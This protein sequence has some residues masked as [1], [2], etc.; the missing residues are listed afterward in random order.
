MGYTMLR[1]SPSLCDFN[2]S[3]GVYSV[4]QLRGEY[5]HALALKAIA[6]AN[7]EPFR[8]TPAVFSPPGYMKYNNQCEGDQESTYPSYDQNSLRPEYYDDYGDLIATYL[9]LL[10]DSLGLDIYAISLQNEPFFNEPYSSC[11]YAGGTHY[12]EMLRVAGPK[13]RQA[14]YATLL[15]GCEHMAWA[16]PSW[17]NAVLADAQAAPYLDRFAIHGYTDGVQVD[18]S[19]FD[20]I[21][22]SGGK[23]LWMSETGGYCHSSTYSQTMTLARTIMKS[24]VNSSMSAWNYCGLVGQECNCGGLVSPDDG[25]KSFAYW[26]HAQFYRFIRPDMKRV[27]ATCSDGQLMVGAFADAGKGSLSLVMIN[28]GS[29]SKDVTLSIGGGAVP[30]QFE[31]R[32][33]SPAGNFVDL[34]MVNAGATIT[35]PASAIVSLGYGHRGVPVKVTQPA[36]PVRAATSASARAAV[37][38]AFDLSGRRVGTSVCRSAAPRV[39]ALVVSGRGARLELTGGTR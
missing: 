31:M 34:G 8:I 2:P 15:Y 20:T 3:P 23:P 22:A 29:T 19:T 13:I 9:R 21:T 27:K 4:S 7:G 6:D 24:L 17:E 10:K 39:R 30:A 32:Q 5:S 18:T 16:Y 33:T 37:R 1:P 14:G 35:V 26:V 36:T 12:A 38:R 11:S 28:N 25:S